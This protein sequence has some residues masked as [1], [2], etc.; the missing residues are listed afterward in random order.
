MSEAQSGSRERG[1]EARIALAVA[2]D[3]LVVARLQ[4]ERGTLHVAEVMACGIA[5]LGRDGWPELEEALRE[6]ASDLGVPGGS[7]D[8]ALLRRLAHA[9]VIPLPPVRRGELASLVRHGARRHFA[10]RDEPLVADACRLP[11]PRSG[12][13]VPTVAACAPAAVVTAVADACEAAG[14]RVGRIVPAAVALAEAVRT[15][16]AAARR[17]RTAALTV[18]AAGTDLVLMEDG[19]PVRVQPLAAG[20]GSAE[21]M[22]DRLRAA[23]VEAEE[24]GRA[25][26]AI[27]VCGAGAEADALRRAVQMDPVYGPRL[28]L[29]LEMEQMPAEAVAALGAALAGPSAPLLLPPALAAARARRARRRTL[30]MASASAVLLLAS[31]GVHLWGLNREIA[32]LQARREEIA[33]SVTRAREMRT[34]V[35]GVRVRLHSLAALEREAAGWTEEI[36]ALAAALP[37]S[38]HLR[39]LAVDSTGLRLAGLARSASDVVPALEAH[40]AFARVSLAAPV[41]FEQGDAGERFDVVAQLQGIRGGGQE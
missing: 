40:P 3:H 24:E 41:R 28:A 13:L 14:F 35:D 7:V 15:R 10:V 37:D 34:N 9:K 20:Q 17:G 33:G 36:A 16:V 25:V 29:A 12:P 31:A 39:T 1:R 5:P 21:G 2:A 4:R 8:V 30:A 19:L 38:A 18:G 27:V 6:L 23:L 32:A 22:I 26:A 11:G